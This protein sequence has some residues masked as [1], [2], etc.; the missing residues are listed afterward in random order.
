VDYFQYRK[1][2]GPSIVADK[3]G[4][5]RYILDGGSKK[6]ALTLLDAKNT[7]KLQTIV[8]GK[9]TNHQLLRNKLNEIYNV[10]D[11]VMHDENPEGTQRV[12]AS[13]VIVTPSYGM[14]VETQNNKYN[15]DGNIYDK[16]IKPIAEALN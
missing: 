4:L 12:Y 13:L 2:M 8:L 11:Q 10:Y 1:F 6:I 15:V 3:V 16:E 9:N 5:F 7:N 14:G